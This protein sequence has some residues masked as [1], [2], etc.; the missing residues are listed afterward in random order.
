MDFYVFFRKCSSLQSLLS[1]LKRKWKNDKDNLLWLL[2]IFWINMCIFQYKLTSNNIV[3]IYS[4]LNLLFSTFK[5]C[6]FYNG[7]WFTNNAV[8][9]SVVHQSD[10]V[11][12]IHVS[13]L[14]W[15]ICSFRLLQN[16]NHNSLWYTVGLYWLLI[17]NITVCTCQSQTPNLSIPY[18]SLQVI[19]LITSF[20]KSVSLFSAKWHSGEKVKAFPRRSGTGQNVHSCYFYS[21]HIGKS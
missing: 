1:Y 4:V 3:S 10:S 21:T 19:P 18:I 6:L 2:F 12:Q 14:F 15:I 16:I 7:A 8:L 20:S 5:K 11:I 13:T 17:L 9:V